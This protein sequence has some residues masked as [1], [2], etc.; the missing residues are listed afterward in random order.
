MLTA[1]DQKMRQLAE[2]LSPPVSLQFSFDSE[3]PVGT[4]RL[5]TLQDVVLN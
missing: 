2:Q 3:K 5:L 4:V 1:L